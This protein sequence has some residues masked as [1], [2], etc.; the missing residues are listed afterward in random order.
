M[1]GAVALAAREEHPSFHER[2]TPD[3]VLLRFL[4]RYQRTLMQLA[5]VADRSV[6]VAFY[7][8]D[9][10]VYDWEDGERV[11]EHFF[12]HPGTVW[13]DPRG[14]RTVPLTFVA[15]A[16]RL[17]PARWPAA[18]LDGDVL[19]LIGGRDAWA[20]SR[21]IILR[22]VPVPG[23]LNA[24][25]PLT[26]PDA[27]EGAL[28][29]ACVDFLARRTPDSDAHPVPRARMETDFKAAEAAFVAALRTRKRGQT[30]RTLNS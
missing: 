24:K 3:G 25:T 6:A 27:A 1:A 21:R 9:V 13:T 11:P 4:A 18:Y 30:N 26:L 23:E 2:N 19:R 29:A 22:Y 28:V 17:Q 20:T 16:Q 10:P 8:L 14:S 12:M 15:H 5:V 7:E